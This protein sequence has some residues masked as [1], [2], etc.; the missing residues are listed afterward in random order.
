MWI[1]LSAVAG[2]ATLPGI[3]IPFEVLD[4]EKS[5]WVLAENLPS[6]LA[7]AGAK[8][9]WELLSVDGLPMTDAV[10]VQRRV[11]KGPARDVQLLFDT[12]ELPEEGEDPVPT[13][14][15]L[16]APRASLIH[17]KR[18]DTV[19]WPE[20]FS[21]VS[22]WKEDWTGA[23]ILLDEDRGTWTFDVN[24]GRWFRVSATDLT[25]RP[26]PSVFWNLSDANWTIDTGSRIIGGNRSWA[27]ERFAKAAR[28]SS[29]RGQVADHLLINTDAGLEVYAID[30]PQGT[31]KLPSC[32]PRV[33]ET[34]LASGLTILTDLESRAGAKA[35]ALRQFGIAC[36]NGVHRAC[37][38]AVALE[39]PSRA[40]G[41]KACLSR[42]VDACNTIAAARFEFDPENPDDV[43]F[44]LLEYACE[45]ESTGTLGERLQRI[46]DIGASCVLLARAF[47]ARKMPELAL[48]NLD[49]ACVLGRADA[50]AE[51]TKRREQAFAAR[52]VRE[53]QDEDVPI[54]AACVELGR[55]LQTSPIPTATVDDFDAFLRACSLGAI[56]GCIELGEY[57]DRWGIGHP[58]VVAAETQLMDSCKTGEQR[59]CVGAGH[60]LVR[61]EPKTKAYGDA[62]LLFSSA[63]NEGLTSGCVA[64]AEQRRI[65]KAKRVD[66]PEKVELWDQACVQNSAEGCEGLGDRLV[67]AKSTVKGAFEAYNR[68]CELGNAHACSEMGQIVETNE[69]RVDNDQPADAY[70]TR[71]CNN[72]DPEGCYWLVEDELPRTGEPEETQYVL[73]DRSCEGEYGPGCERLAEVHIDRKTSFDNEI[74]AR[75]F[76]SACGNG[77]YESCRTLGGMYLKGKGVEKD[78]QKARELL[79]RF[80]LNERARHLRLGVTVGLPYGVA[81]EAEG[82]LP[83]PIGPGLAVNAHYSFIPLAG[84]ALLAVEDQASLNATP[85]LTIYG[86]GG[87]FYPNNKGRGLFIGAGFHVLSAQGGGLADLPDPNVTDNNDAPRFNPP[88]SSGPTRTRSG[89]NAKV[90]IR[91]QAKSTYS[92][93]EIGLATYGSLNTNHF[94]EFSENVALPLLLPSVAFSFGFATL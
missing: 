50:C 94:D 17:A 7:N 47:D 63:C 26:I 69:S 92:M 60:L 84:T 36:A 64:G 85:D 87:R 13:E 74:A 82:L 34:C 10:A 35:E 67:K 40:P 81:A 22:T 75:H 44:G 73:L 66:A 2:A 80:R 52:T 51:A 8:P 33:P 61:H 18:L 19:P 39:E 49:Q 31:P 28:V 20:D 70:L 5:T 24:E 59:A 37:Y 83:L 56:D 42:K 57:V 16:V 1:L 77:F 9:G 76:D 3:A 72:G 32:Q 93:V 27:K 88:K 90:G 41:V 79:E 21:P 54:A 14:V 12:A 23:P 46:E 86:F 15:L 89:F 30:Y 29:Y 62:L 65:G 43:V 68:S 53:C 48:L 91:S 45:L 71:G 11:A 6:G 58:R 78:R 25:D 55:L 38:E 4:D